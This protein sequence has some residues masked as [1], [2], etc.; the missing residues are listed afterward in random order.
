MVLQSVHLDFTELEQH[1]ILPD[2]VFQVAAQQSSM[3]ASK[4][5][6]KTMIFPCCLLLALVLRGKLPLYMDVPL[7]NQRHTVKYFQVAYML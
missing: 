6:V 2:A 7:K 3:D 1:S 4:E 5:G